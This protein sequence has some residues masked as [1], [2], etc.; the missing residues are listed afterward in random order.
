[1]SRK[2]I[3]A[4][5][6]DSKNA[7]NSETTKANVTCKLKLVSFEEEEEEEKKKKKRETRTR[8]KKEM[9]RKNGKCR[10]MSRSGA[11]LK[12]SKDS[13]NPLFSAEFFTSRSGSSPRRARQ[14]P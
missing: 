12:I 9:E 6:R 4:D 5:A 10:G 7:L 13:T 14:H 2:V 3:K 8:A 1:M 11:V